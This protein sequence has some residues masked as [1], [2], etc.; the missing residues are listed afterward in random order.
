MDKMDEF[1]E[2]CERAGEKLGGCLK[3]VFI[4]VA[5]IIGL[6]VMLREC[7]YD[8]GPSD[9]VKDQAREELK[10]EREQR[11]RENQEWDRKVREIQ[12]REAVDREKEKM[13]GY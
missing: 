8:E 12:H 11:T 1:G 4:I 2:K 10:E 6:S 3:T 9:P 7:G 5:S 13:R